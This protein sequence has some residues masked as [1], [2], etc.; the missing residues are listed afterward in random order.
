MTAMMIGDFEQGMTAL[1]ADSARSPF[2]MARRYVDCDE[3]RAYLRVGPRLIEGRQQQ[4]IQ[5]A[6]VDVA[7]EQQRNG[8]FTEFLARLRGVCVLPVFVEN[9]LNSDF[10]DALIRRGF[11]V[12]SSDGYSRCLFID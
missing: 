1:L 11:R 4:C 10:G 8:Q 2:K 12:V 5:I 7:E 3:L 9:V 6:T